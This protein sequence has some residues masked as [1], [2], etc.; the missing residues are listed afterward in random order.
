MNN[1]ET[2]NGTKQHKKCERNEVMDR[3]AREV[4]WPRH[5]GQSKSNGEEK[6]DAIDP[7]KAGMVPVYFFPEIRLFVR[8]TVCLIYGT[9]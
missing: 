9:E 2:V 5:D 8:F 4:R 1:H 3:T 7:H 6:T